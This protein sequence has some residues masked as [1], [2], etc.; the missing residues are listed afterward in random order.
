MRKFEQAAY[1]NLT[2]VHWGMALDLSS[3]YNR[4]PIAFG[5]RG[6]EQQQ[7][8]KQLASFDFRPWPRN[9]EVGKRDCSHII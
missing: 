7:V 5:S 2:N 1:S 9:P 4:S 6:W 3:A 8:S